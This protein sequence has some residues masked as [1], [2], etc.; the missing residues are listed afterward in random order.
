MACLL[1]LKA[2]GKIRAIGVSNVSLDELKENAEHGE[3]ASNQLRYSVLHREPEREILPYCAKRKIATLTYMSLEQ[4]L[5]TG[6]IGMGRVFQ[7]NEFRANEAWNPWYTK[8]N[9]RRVLDLLSDW[10]RF[11]ERYECSLAQLVIAWTAAQPGVTH[12]LC[13]ARRVEQ[14]KENV[15]AGELQL[16]AETMAQMRRDVDG[17][18]EPIHEEVVA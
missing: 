4:G 9:R 3:V 5:L 15:C 18:G 11:A 14:A 1:K 17:L 7:K 6:K 2:Q 12:V 10:R 16:D 13:G 8:A